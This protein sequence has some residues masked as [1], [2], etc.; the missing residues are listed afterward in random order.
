MN[1]QI[2]F[3]F[4][5]KGHKRLFF[6][7]VEYYIPSVTFRFFLVKS[8]TCCLI[9]ILFSQS[10]SP[11]KIILLCMSNWFSS[12]REVTNNAEVSVY[13]NVSVVFYGKRAR[14]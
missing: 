5:V 12:T 8:R 11:E 6:I 13:I 1:Y 3:G 7:D 10:L 4:N 14:F 2:I 9:C